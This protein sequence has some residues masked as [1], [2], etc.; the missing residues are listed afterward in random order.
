MKVMQCWD[1]SVTNDIRLV[2]LLRQYHAKATFNFIITE[3]E[4]GLR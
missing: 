3:D 4:G 2:E 1:D